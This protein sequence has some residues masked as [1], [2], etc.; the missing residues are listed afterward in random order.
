[1][2]RGHQGMPSALAFSPGAST[3]AS[4][5]ADRT[6]RLTRLDGIVHPVPAESGLQEALRLHGLTWDEERFLIH[7][8]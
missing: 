4:A 8:R 5:G 3:L 7:F 1:V 2:V 6:I